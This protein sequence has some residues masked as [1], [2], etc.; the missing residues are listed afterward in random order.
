MGHKTTEFRQAIESTLAEAQQLL[1]EQAAKHA[2]DTA[3]VEAKNARMID[4]MAYQNG[5]LQDELDELKRYQKQHDL[6][7]DGSKPKGVGDTR[8]DSP[9]LMTDDM[10][11]AR[12]QRSMLDPLSNPFQYAKE[13]L[14]SLVTYDGYEVEYT[15]SVIPTAESEALPADARDPQGPAEKPSGSSRS[16][17]K[18][19]APVPPLQFSQGPMPT[20]RKQGGKPPGGPPPDDDG[21]G[22]GDEDEGDGLGPN[23]GQEAFAKMLM[24]L[25]KGH[26]NDEKPRTR[27]SETLRFK[28]MPTP[29][30]Y[31]EWKTSVREDVRAA[32]DRPDE[33]WPWIMEVWSDREDKKKLLEE[34]G[35]PGKF[36]TLDTKILAALTRSAKGDLAQR[37][38]TAKEE[39]AKEGKAMRGRQVL[40]MFDQYFKTS[41]EAG[42]LYSLEDL[43]RV[44]RHGEGII[45]LKRFLNAWDSVIAGMKRPPEEK[46]LKDILLRQVR[47]CH[48]LRYDIDTYDRCRDDDPNKSYDS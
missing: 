40:F 7:E 10:K 29:E 27:E 38:L 17:V 20:D 47:S 14:R 18:T 25:V 34:L 31:R 2:D 19:S 48:L 30:T 9:E 42:N 13:K 43:L 12:S 41:E 23:L 46:V 44:S 28:E 32:S 33:A 45:D 15:P 21:D 26:T 3:R 11:S 5:L 39:C 36:V 22:D 4:M 8:E 16:Q 35:E 6:R 1:H 24:K 37:I